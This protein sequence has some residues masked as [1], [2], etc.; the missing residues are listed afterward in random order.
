MI[1]ILKKSTLLL[2]LVSSIFCSIF[3]SSCERNA[4]FNDFNIV[5]RSISE[6]EVYFELVPKKDIEDVTFFIYLYDYEMKNF[7]KLRRPMGD[8]NKGE[9]YTVTYT[10]ESYLYPDKKILNAKLEI[11]TGKIVYF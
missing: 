2:L 11:S 9:T 6:T 5:R 3:F 1:K 4:I 7:A 10:L 8:M